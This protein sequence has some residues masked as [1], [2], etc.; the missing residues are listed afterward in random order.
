MRGISRLHVSF[1]SLI[2]INTNI[3]SSTFL[4][5]VSEGDQKWL[6]CTIE[7][8]FESHAIVFAAEESRKKGI[9]VRMD[10]Y[11]ALK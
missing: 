8:M 3:P 1:S 6:G 11:L 9:V 10:D 5:A 2:F 7:D 4:K